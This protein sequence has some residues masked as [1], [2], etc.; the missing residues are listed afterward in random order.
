VVKKTKRKTA[1]AVSN[2][3]YLS[4]YMG[5]GYSKVLEPGKN[6]KNRW[7]KPF[8]VKDG[9]GKTGTRKN[10]E[11]VRFK[12]GPRVPRSGFYSKAL[13]LSYLVTVT[14]TGGIKRW[15]KKS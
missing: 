5:I 2:N 3:P 4:L 11:R 1:E 13:A 14:C 15:D 9:G 12:G 8:L 10:R 6:E 7:E